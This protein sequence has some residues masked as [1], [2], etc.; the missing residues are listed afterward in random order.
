MKNVIVKKVPDDRKNIWPEKNYMIDMRDNPDAPEPLSLRGWTF[1][2]EAKFDK[3]IKPKL[4]GPQFCVWF[5]PRFTRHQVN[6]VKAAFAKRCRDEGITF[7]YIF[8][9]IPPP[10]AETVRL[11]KEYNAKHKREEEA[12]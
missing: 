10:R 8:K 3:K 1:N 4:K 2:I 5:F 12:A 9:Q 7:V 11:I 6:D